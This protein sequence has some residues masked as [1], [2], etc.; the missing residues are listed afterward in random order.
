MKKL[1]V[2]LLCLVSFYGN[3][4]KMNPAFLEGEWTS[5]GESTEMIFKRTP[6]NKLLISEY[7]SISGRELKILRHR[8]K[9]N[10]L[11][12]ESLFEPNNFLSITKLIIIDQDT[13]VADI[14][15][16]YPGQVIYKRILNDKIN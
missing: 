5:N 9:K 6:D 14:V 11:Y 8:I 10:G 2:L 13:M 12:I 7:S 16:D 3:A 15:S 1:L 4:Q